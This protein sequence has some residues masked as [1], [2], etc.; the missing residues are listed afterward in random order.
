[1]TSPIDSRSTTTLLRLPLWK[2]VV[3]WIPLAGIAY[4]AFWALQQPTDGVMSLPAAR[5]WGYVCGIVITLFLIYM[6]IWYLFT[7]GAMVVANS[8]AIWLRQPYAW[9]NKLRKRP[10]R[11]TG[12]LSDLELREYGIDVDSGGIQVIFRGT[13]GELIIETSKHAVPDDIYERFRS[14]KSNLGDPTAS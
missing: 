6:P 4:G 1:M 14:W 8:E 2:L 10:S 13:A 3:G 5:V 9:F 11:L 12:D 7:R